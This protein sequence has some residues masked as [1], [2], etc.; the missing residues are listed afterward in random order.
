MATNQ[1][2]T[3][4]LVAL[5]PLGVGLA[6]RLT[7]ALHAEPFVDEP[8]TMLVAQAVARTGVPV[9]PS[10]LFYGNDLPFSYLA[11]ALV[12][13]FG[14][15]LLAVRLLSVAA[16]IATIALV[17]TAGRRLFSP[18]AGLWAALL[19]ALAPQEIVWG[20]RAR[21]YA[22]LELLVLASAWLFYAGVS[23]DRAGPRRLGLFLLVAAIFVHPEAALL[24]PALVVAAG[25]IKGWRWWTRPVHLAELALAV[26]GAGARYLLQV[27]L[28]RG[29]IGGYA[30]V[31][32]SRPPLQLPFDLPARLADVAPFSS[33]RSACPGPCSPCWP[34]P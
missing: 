6:L 16:S 32:G 21:A 19:L 27:A 1:R 20:S 34:W 8:T 30:T 13:L 7:Y 15:H 5:L 12:A 28:A 31:A 25:L 2:R 14:P 11:G 33:T 17:Y 24:L 10:G 22:L 3:A 9:L 4:V 23:R 18:Q 26:A 29:W